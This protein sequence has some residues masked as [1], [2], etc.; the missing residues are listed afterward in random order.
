MTCGELHNRV[1]SIHTTFISY[2][3][4]S[5]LIEKT[6]ID[7]FI[8]YAGVLSHEDNEVD[9][10]FFDRKSASRYIDSAISS[11]ITN[12]FFRD[13]LPSNFAH[14]YDKLV[15][16]HNRNILI[17]TITAIVEMYS[18]IATKDAID[19]YFVQDEY[20]NADISSAIQLLGK[21]N[22]F[23][24]KE[25][26]HEDFE[27]QIVAAINSRRDINDTVEQEAV[28]QIIDYLYDLELIVSIPMIYHNSNDSAQRRGR[29]FQYGSCEYIYQAG[30]KYCQARAILDIL[31]SSNDVD[32]SPAEREVLSKKIDEDIKG[33]ILEISI[34]NEL[35]IFLDNKKYDIFKMNFIGKKDGEIDIVIYDKHNK[36]YYCFEVKHSNQTDE[37]QQ[38][39]LSYRPF[40]DI[41]D[42]N[43]GE[44]RISAVL[45][46]GETLPSNDNGV[47]Y[48]NVET[49]LSSLYL[50]PEPNL[51]KIIQQSLDYGLNQIEYESGIK[52]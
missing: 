17:P 37:H 31:K 5:R 12:T 21:H 39:N 38:V 46:R 18:G 52:I 47:T 45:Y 1:N 26:S 7:D 19:A 13:K 20:F 14:K 43:F 15:G 9:R 41:M 3:E 27:G 48:L 32:L 28:A 40:Q 42:K 4:F 11:N 6:D 49:F 16:L 51:N 8:H 25:K 29:E 23:I 33:H 34:F 44:R 24:N 35:I 22:I 10:E 2:G 36:E 50:A 30:I